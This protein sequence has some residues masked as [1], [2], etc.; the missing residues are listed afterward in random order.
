M[1]KDRNIQCYS[2]DFSEKYVS[3]EEAER[4]MKNSYNIIKRIIS[5]EDKFKDILFLIGVSNTDSATAVRSYLYTGR[6]GR[7]LVLIEGA[8]I[9][10]HIHL[11]VFNKNKN[12]YLLSTFCDV[13]I[14]RLK[15]YGVWEKRANDNLEV[16]LQYVLKQSV[17]YR[18]NCNAILVSL[19]K[20]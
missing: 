6:R 2:I 16:A 14:E 13:A 7:P 11:Y 1:G 5:R 18:S 9:E 4:I 10:P 3:L 20:K 15:K 17:H 19:N 12:S 8:K